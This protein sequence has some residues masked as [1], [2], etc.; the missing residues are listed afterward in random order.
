MTASTVSP[1]TASDIKNTIRDLNPSTAAHEFYT[2]RLDSIGSQLESLID[3]AFGSSAD[4]D[5]VRP[6]RR[7]A[8]H[9]MI[10]DTYKQHWKEHYHAA[11]K[12]VQCSDTAR[13]V[14]HDA[15]AKAHQRRE[16]FEGRAAMS[17][18]IFRIVVNQALDLLRSGRYKMSVHGGAKDSGDTAIERQWTAHD[19]VPKPFTCPERALLNKERLGK[20]QLG[21]D[22]MKPAKRD[23]LLAHVIDGKSMKEIAAEEDKPVG[24][25]LSRISTARAELR[26]G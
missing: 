13:D 12:I 1:V 2:G 9:S 16:Q 10:A 7:L 21:L 22:K 8:D 5:K 14:C 24:T 15:Y 17:S 19:V 20:L 6:S 3:D 26:K 11:W 4:L 23:A 18:Y 25:I